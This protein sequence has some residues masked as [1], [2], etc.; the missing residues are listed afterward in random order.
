[1]ALYDA[2]LLAACDD[3]EAGIRPAA[4]GDTPEQAAAKAIPLPEGVRSSTDREAADAIRLL[5]FTGARLQEVLKA[6]WPQFNLGAGIWEKPSAHTK[7]K[8][9]HRLELEGPA[10]DLL[11]AMGER[12]SHALY[13]FPGS[14]QLR[15]KNAPVDIKTGEPQ[16]IAPR[17]DLKRPWAAISA[18]AGLEGV[19]LHDLRRTTASFMLSGGSS[20]ATVGKA[21]GHTQA[22][23]TQRYATLAPSVQRSGLGD[24]GRRMVASKERKPAA[25]IMAFPGRGE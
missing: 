24:A 3:Y 7:T 20:L 19:K 10:L 12:K 8:R 9:Q 17:S 18:M 23:T 1:M 16:D 4:E 21:L 14:P 5:L 11:Q 15:R 13:L 6:E 22:S 2:R 25:S